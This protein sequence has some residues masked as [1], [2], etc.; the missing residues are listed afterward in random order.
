[1]GTYFGRTHKTCCVNTVHAFNLVTGAVS[2]VSL[3][4]LAYLSAWLTMM[5]SMPSL[6]LDFAVPFIRI[7]IDQNGSQ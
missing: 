5:A 6:W 1:M 7:V 2:Y 4:N 3:V